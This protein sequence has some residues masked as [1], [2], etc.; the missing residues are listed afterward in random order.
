MRE[1]T[2]GVRLPKQC[3]RERLIWG[4]TKLRR[5]CVLPSGWAVAAEF[6]DQVSNSRILQ[7]FQCQGISKTPMGRR[8]GGGEAGGRGVHNL[9][10]LRQ[11]F[12]LRSGSAV[13]R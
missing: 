10:A 3:E 13:D 2:P 7:G 11:D 8:G 12:A 9:G 5:G 6:R 1:I 4:Y